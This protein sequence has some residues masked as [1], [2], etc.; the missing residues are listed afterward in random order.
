MTSWYNP[1]IARGFNTGLSLLLQGI[2]VE[3]EMVVLGRVQL[4]YFL[5]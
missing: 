3:L 4:N 1:V 5:L 2:A